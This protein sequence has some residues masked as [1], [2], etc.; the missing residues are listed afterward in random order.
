[1]TNSAPISKCTTQLSTQHSQQTPYSRRTDK[2]IVNRDLRTF[3]AKL[4]RIASGE[5]PFGW[6]M[7]SRS[8]PNNYSG[9][10]RRSR[11]WVCRERLPTSRALPTNLKG[12][13]WPPN[14]SWHFNTANILLLYFVLCPSL[15]RRAINYLLSFC[16]SSW[17]CHCRTIPD[18]M[19]CLLK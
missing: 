2:F 18:S 8:I 14:N 7:V 16:L 5:A 3:E 15:L 9:L 11:G 4:H 6:R 10:H 1:M 19:L 13:Q 12:T 17:S